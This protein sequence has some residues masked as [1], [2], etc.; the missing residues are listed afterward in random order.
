MT[1]INIFQTI[2]DTTHRIEPFH[3]Q[4]LGD[5]LRA[6]LAGDRSLF[7]EIWNLCTPVDW[8]PPKNAK[9]KNE[10]KLDGG[11]RI[12]ILIKDK[13][14]DKDKDKKLGYRV[15]IEV[16][17]SRA[18]ARAGQLEAY[19]AGLKKKYAVEQIAIAYLTP[20]NRPRAEEIIKE[21]NRNSSERVVHGN[22]DALSTVMVFEKFRKSFDP[23]LARHVSWLDVAEIEW[24]G[25][26]IWNQHQSYIRTKI[27]SPDELER[28]LSRNRLL[29]EFFSE[30]AVEDFWESLWVALPK[31]ERK[32]TGEPVIID[33][34]SFEGGPEKLVHALTFLIEDDEYV[35]R[36]RE[37]PN[38]FDDDA[39][40]QGFLNSASRYCRFHEAMFGLTRRFKYVW[41]QGEKNYGLRVAHKDHSSGVSLVTSQGKNR[42]TIGRRR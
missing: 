19:L 41:V 21:M 2:K 26:E 29:D 20:F 34:D 27:A 22:A 12:D 1:A 38:R 28:A 10:F 37:R 3:S 42:L 40:R 23:T 4:F 15:G 30:Q 16:K 13:D 36:R 25:G 5:A 33:L 6:S 7:E 39:S 11:Q 14:K 18:S 24:E 17:T 35:D 32:R 31:S 9:V 8:A